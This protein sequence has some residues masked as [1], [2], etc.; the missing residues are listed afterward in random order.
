VPDRSRTPPPAGPGG[1]PASPPPSGAAGSGVARGVPPGAV[2]RGRLVFGG[3]ASGLRVDGGAPGAALYRVRPASPGPRVRTRGDVAVVRFPSG[4]PARGWPARPEGPAEIALGA[5]VRWQIAF[6]G[7]ASHVAADLRG[8]ALAGLAF[9][10]GAGR[11]TVLLPAPSGTV[12]ARILGGARHVVLHRPPG[13]AVRLRV[14]GGATGVALD[15]QHVGVAGGELSL[16]A[17]GD[18]RA[19]GRYEVVVTGGANLLLVG[20]GPPPPGGLEGP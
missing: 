2:R 14:R 13:T 7:G 12:P 5:G 3:G 10:G 20:Q 15:G 6:R 4:P 9:D 17:P 16:H 19:A 1:A 11:V 8:L 18:G